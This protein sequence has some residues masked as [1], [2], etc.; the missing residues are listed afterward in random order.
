[1]LLSFN[2]GC[3]QLRPEEF[4]GF[5]WKPLLRANWGMEGDKAEAGGE[6]M[7]EKKFKDE[8]EEKKFTKFF[9]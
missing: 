6:K 8:Y 1:M 3:H 5:F 2:V 7:E 9:E 4:V